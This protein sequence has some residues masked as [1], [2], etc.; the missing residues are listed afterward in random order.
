VPADNKWYTRMVVGAA[1]VDALS[2]VDLH[3]PKLDAAAL[4]KLAESR[5]RLMAE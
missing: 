1:I 3:M 5:A 4:A 2:S